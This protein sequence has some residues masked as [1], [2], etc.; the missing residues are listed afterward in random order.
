MTEEEESAIITRD[1][2]ILACA[3]LEHIRA[4]GGEAAA[5]AEETLTSFAL[6]D[7]GTK[8]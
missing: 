1:R 7:E 6:A 4:L 3:A 2:L 5:I 8:E